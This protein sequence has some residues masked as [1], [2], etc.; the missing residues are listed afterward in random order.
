MFHMKDQISLKPL[1]LMHK[2]FALIIREFLTDIKTQHTIIIT[3]L[4]IAALVVV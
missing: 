1:T 2:L 4:V 3:F